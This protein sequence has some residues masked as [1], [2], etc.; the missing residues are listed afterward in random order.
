MSLRDG[1]L[2]PNND[3]LRLKEA[4]H[5]ASSKL[6][7]NS[8]SLSLWQI[9]ETAVTGGFLIHDGNAVAAKTVY[10]AVRQFDFDDDRL[11]DR[12]SVV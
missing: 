11:A 4:S 12:K 7:E 8:E 10:D 1:S 6:F 2:L 9:T 5:L 3:N